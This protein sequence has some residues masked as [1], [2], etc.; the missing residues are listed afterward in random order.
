M[1]QSVSAEALAVLES[2]DRDTDTVSLASTNLRVVPDEVF[3]SFPSMTCLNVSRNEVS[4]LPNTFHEL[5]RIKTFFCNTNL[6]TSLPSS[7]CDGLETLTIL[8]VQRNRLSS[9]PPLNLP[10]L[11]ELEVQDNMLQELPPLLRLRSLRHL[12]VNRNKLRALPPSITALTS[13]DS[14]NI[15]NNCLT[16]IPEAICLLASSLRYLMASDNQIDCIPDTVTKLTLLDTLMLDK[17]RIQ[18]A[19]DSLAFLPSV[20]LC[21]LRGNPELLDVPQSFHVHGSIY[22][23][24]PSQILPNLYLGP[25]GASENI[26]LLKRLGIT[27]ILRAVDA[28]VQDR[29]PFDDSMFKYLW[30]DCLDTDVQDMA[31]FFESSNAFLESDPNGVYLVH[32]RQGKSRSATLVCAY[33]I[34][35]KKLPYLEALEYVK[36][37]RAMARPNPSFHE[38]LHRYA[39]KLGYSDPNLVDL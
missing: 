22:S 30:I 4:K 14:L 11:T 1:G 36:A 24:V 7:L 2:L 5:K 6:L 18:K 25:V 37:R 8:S 15:Q 10:S 38:Q 13:L 20:S 32:C 19:N 26:A 12:N 39:A 27:H 9:L 29:Q 35:S 21:D 28:S 33:L 3:S 34:Y 16:S 31:Q 17:N 23:D